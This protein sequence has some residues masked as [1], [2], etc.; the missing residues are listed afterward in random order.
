MKTF[1]NKAL[2]LS[3][4]LLWLTS[5]PVFAAGPNR[6]GTNAASELLIPVG[7]KYIAMGGASVA[8][9][10]G[11]EALYWNPAGL[12]KMS[13]QAEAMFSV[14][15]YLADINVNYVGVG[16]KFGKLGSVGLS[17]K[18]LAI[19]DIPI[20]TE[21]APDGTGELFSPQ[22]ITLGLSYSRALTDRVAVGAT[23]KLINETIDRVGATGFAFDIGVQY[24]NLGD[25]PGLNIGLVIK[26]LGSGMRF[27]G[28]GLLRVGNPL[29]AS[30]AASPY[31]IVAGTDELPST[32][33]LGIGYNLQLGE[34]SKFNFQTLVVNNNY[35]DDEAKLGV[36]YSFNDMFFLRGGYNFSVNN[37]QDARGDAAYIFGPAFGAGFHYD[38]AGLSLD[39]DY[40]FRQV[41]YFDANNVFSLKVGF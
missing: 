29:D 13:Y 2:I 37:T 3:L 39:F 8:G 35:L 38:L 19:G 20:T 4:V 15:T 40:A 33:E 21:D 18:T 9:V 11:L 10:T 12:D 6:A 16:I 27:D 14:M 22:F 36:E 24:T 25:I 23:A 7:A 32:M 31:K 34:T 17:F 26:N 1:L 30:R 41:D 5:L 28:N